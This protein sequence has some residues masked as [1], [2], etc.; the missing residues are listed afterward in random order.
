MKSTAN[1][2]NQPA[3]IVIDN[4][5]SADKRWRS[6]SAANQLREVFRTQYKQ[7]TNP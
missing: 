7:E 1:T 6:E 5:L 2:D 3:N 4:H